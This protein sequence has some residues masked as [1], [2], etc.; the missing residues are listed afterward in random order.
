MNNDHYCCHPDCD[1]E[2]NW[3]I[4]T[5]YDDY[6]EMCDDHVEEYKRDGDVVTRID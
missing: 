1:K 6:T 2:A 4:Y 3:Q 5:S